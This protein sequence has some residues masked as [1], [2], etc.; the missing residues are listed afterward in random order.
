[1]KL[2]GI[3]RNSVVGSQAAE[4][5]IGR[6]GFADRVRALAA[7]TGQSVD[8]VRNEA[9]ASLNEMAADQSAAAVMAWSRAGEWLSRGYRIEADTQALATLRS[10]SDQASLVFLPNHRSY[11]DPFVLRSVLADWGF[12][13][14][15]IL[16]GVNLS[17]FPL[18]SIARRSNIV[19]IRRQFRDAPVYR[20]MLG[21]YLA[22]LVRTDANL[23]WYIEGGRTRT[24]KLRPPRMGILSYLL[25]AFDRSDVDDLLFVPVSIIY[26]QQH[27]VGL[28]AEE[29]SGG[30]KPPEGVRWLVDYARA[31][32]NRRGAAHV[33]FAEAVSLREVLADARAAAGTDDVRAAVPRVAFEVSHRINQVTPITA[34]ALVMLTLMDNGDRAMTEAQM[35]RSLMPVAEYIRDRGLAV[36]AGLD[37]SKVDVLTTRSPSEGRR[38]LDTLVREGVVSEYS[39]GLEPVYSIPADRQLEAA[40]YRNTL[41]HFFVTRSI[42][43]LAL[44]KAAED[45]APDL[46]G[47]VWN[48]ALRLRDLLKYE[49]FFSTKR[50]FDAEVRQE[51]ELAFPGWHEVGLTAD[52]VLPRLA[53]SHLLLAHR[54]LAPFL[55]AYAVLA[56]RLAATDATA[57]VDSAALVAECIAVARQRV[58]QRSIF[59]PESVS[60]DLFTNA[61]QLAGNR[62]LLEP[63][64]P[65]L[66]HRREQFAA[67]LADAV[68]RVDLV[69]TIAWE[70]Q[71]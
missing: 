43:E 66:A 47:A 62:G 48:E 30:V 28:I 29:E 21:E 56:D 68:R 60:K 8:E 14:N 27:E 59:S 36:S 49:F 34:S 12:P 54:I 69:R 3:A 50:E 15:H 52:E 4:S 67:E 22:H 6:P 2:P 65:D 26:D 32:G 38:A 53:A 19:F 44:L 1:M 46:S 61:L 58:L 55:E 70:A 20:A 7:Q 16:G 35:R 42:T 5:I 51:A 25:D 9:I 71:A 45:E 23:E 17:F 39:G 33:R 41:S 64:Q 40:F 13:P 10:V 31:Q 57:P 11:L 24:G 37:L 63:D 18:G